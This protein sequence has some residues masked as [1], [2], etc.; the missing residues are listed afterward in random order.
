M[1]FLLAFHTSLDMILENCGMQYDLQPALSPWH[2]STYNGDTFYL[3]ASPTIRILQLAI[4][5]VRV[6]F[7]Y[8][9]MQPMYWLHSTAWNWGIAILHEYWWIYMTISPHPQR[10]LQRWVSFPITSDWIWCV[11]LE[12]QCQ[13][14]VFLYRQVHT[15][16]CIK[17][18]SSLCLLGSSSLCSAL[19]D[20][21]KI[22]HRFVQITG[23]LNIPAEH[24]CCH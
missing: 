3:E 1:W 13:L 12:L 9:T 16:S 17:K 5:Q 24:C 22:I 8:V 2:H 21:H 19:A 20:F 23:S 11:D 14:V 15:S 7:N 6:Y 10:T 4:W 18:L